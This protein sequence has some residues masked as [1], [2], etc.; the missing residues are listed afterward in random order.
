[1]RR[2]LVSSIC[3]YS[4]FYI[5]TARLFPARQQKDST[6]TF[7][8]ITRHL[9]SG[10]LAEALSRRLRTA[11]KRGCRRHRF[12]LAAWLRADVD[13]DALVPEQHRMTFV[14]GHDIEGQKVCMVRSLWQLAVFCMSA[15][16]V[17]WS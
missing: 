4:G 16:C 1:M 14:S 5:V 17:H 3:M 6:P 8:T 7:E 2:A 15:L 10:A 12:F 9:S 11:H 13:T